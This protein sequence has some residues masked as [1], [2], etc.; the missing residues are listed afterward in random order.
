MHVVGSLHCH[1]DSFTYYI[2]LLTRWIYRG[3]WTHGF[4]GRYGVRQSTSSGACYAGTW[5]TGLQDGY[6]VE[7]YV[8]GGKYRAE[9]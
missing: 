5:T 4:K 1:A 7:V 6:G 2:M 3:E 9:L 8:D